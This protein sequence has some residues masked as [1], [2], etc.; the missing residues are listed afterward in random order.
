[1]TTAQQ[2]RTAGLDGMPELEK[3][4]NIDRSTL[5]RWA[6]S[7]KRKWLFDACVEKAAREKSQIEPANARDDLFDLMRKEYN[8]ELIESELDSII[9][10]VLSSLKI[11]VDGEK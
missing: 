5:Y 9:Y 1:M 4:S 6:K 7:K 3:I 10:C 2:I 8:M 11:K